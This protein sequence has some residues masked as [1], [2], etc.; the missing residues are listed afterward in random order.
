MVIEVL[1]W[2]GAVVILAGYALFSLGRLRDG[3][4]YQG[5][6]LVGSALIAVN[7]AAHGAVASAVVNTIWASIAIGV[8]TRTLLLRRAAGRRAGAAAEAVAAPLVAAPLVGPAPAP[9]PEPAP[10]TAPVPLT[11]SVAVITG[12]IAIIALAASQQ[13]ADTQQSDAERVDAHEAA[14]AS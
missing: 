5:V 11:D 3:L 6:N 4:A 13:H 2:I 9:E 1:G 8:I 12:A 7:V 14:A 10:A